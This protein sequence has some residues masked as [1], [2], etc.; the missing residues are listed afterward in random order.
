MRIKNYKLFLESLNQDPFLDDEYILHGLFTPFYDK[1]YE[2]EVEHG[3]IG[4]DG[5]FR[6]LYPIK[7]KPLAYKVK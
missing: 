4:D 6:A 7:N 1:Y 5:E 2:I 3:Y